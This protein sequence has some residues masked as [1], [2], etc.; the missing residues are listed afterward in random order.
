LKKEII[1]IGCGG[2]AR[3]LIEVI[4]SSD[5]YRIAGLIGCPNEVG[6]KIF[7][8]SVIGSDSDLRDIRQRIFYAVLAIG[9]I[10]LSSKRKDIATYLEELKFTMPTISAKSSIVSNHASL[11]IGVTIFH[12]AIVNAGAIIGNNCILNS[13]A[14]IEHDVTIGAQCHIS[15]GVIIN[16][17]VSIGSGSFIGSNAMVREGLKIPSNTVISAGKRV[18]QWPPRNESN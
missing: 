13:R 9:Q 17:G 5:D 10:G 7:G 12:G 4:E 15:T 16:G 14:L 6:S 3:S 1:L 11:G 8:Y 2:H 18:M